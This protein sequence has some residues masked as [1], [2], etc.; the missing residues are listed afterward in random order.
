MIL[1]RC[2]DTKAHANMFLDG[3]LRMMS[4]EYYRKK[5]MMKMVEKIS[6]KAQN[7]YGRVKIL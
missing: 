3:K 7:F 1:C 4:L 2:F 5:K 6:M